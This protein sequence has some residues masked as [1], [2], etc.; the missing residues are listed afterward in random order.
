MIGLDFEERFSRAV[1]YASRSTYSKM[2]N[3]ILIGL[4]SAEY[5]SVHS[6]C[7]G[8]PMPALPAEVVERIVGSVR[9]A[10]SGIATADVRQAIQQKLVNCGKP[11]TAK[12]KDNTANET[13]LE[14]FSL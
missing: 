4:Y 1:N 14:P 11:K 3:D 10:F 6:L 9:D 12:P 13:V 7:G 8:G 5:L 2:V